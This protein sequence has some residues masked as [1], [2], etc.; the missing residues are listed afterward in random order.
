MKTRKLASLF[1]TG[2][3]GMLMIVSDASATN[4]NT[5]AAL[6][7]NYNAGEVGYFD[8]LTNGVR[9]IDSSSARPVLCSI[10]RSPLG[11]AA[12]SGGF[13]I[14]GDNSSGASTSCTLLSY[15]YTGTFLGAVS[16][17]ESQAHYDHFVTMTSTQLPFYAYTA[18]LC[19]LPTNGNGLL[20]GMTAVQ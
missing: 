7:A 19:Y 10:P 13:Y 17:T 8:R 4:I 1:V 12:A 9:N 16:F 20:R 11:S 2:M 3:M 6:C 15:D 14:D 18:I 5:Q